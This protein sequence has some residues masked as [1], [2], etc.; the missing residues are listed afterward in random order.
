MSSRGLSLVH[1]CEGRS[2]FFPFL[3]KGPALLDYDPT[4]MTSFNLNYILR[5]LS[6]NMVTLGVRASIYQFFWRGVYMNTVHSRDIL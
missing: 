1:A 5:V 6:A 4:P 2:A 3:R